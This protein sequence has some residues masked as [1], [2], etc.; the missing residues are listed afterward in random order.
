MNI[1]DLSHRFEFNN[2]TTDNQVQPVPPYHDSLEFNGDRYLS[3]EGNFSVGKRDAHRL[4]IDAF[5]EARAKG[6]VNGQGRPDQ[7]C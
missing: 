6:S 5:S 2:N 3:R 4:L 7:V 1:E